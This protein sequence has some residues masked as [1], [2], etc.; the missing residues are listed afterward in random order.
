MGLNVTDRQRNG[1]TAT[2]RIY[3]RTIGREGRI[4]VITVEGRLDLRVVPRPYKL[5]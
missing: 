2:W 3:K 5:L 1:R 4:T